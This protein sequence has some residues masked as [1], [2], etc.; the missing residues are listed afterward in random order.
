MMRRKII[1]III[2]LLTI[3]LI[4][5]AQQAP[6]FKISRVDFN[7]SGFSNISPVIVKDEFCF[8]QTEG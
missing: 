2:I 5:S 6:P 7:T 4:V 1:H 3:P 8:A